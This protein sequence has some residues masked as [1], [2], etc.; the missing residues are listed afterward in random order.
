MFGSLNTSLK[1]RLIIIQVITA[2]VAI[3]LSGFFFVA[4]TYKTYNDREVNSLYSI[5]KVVGDNIVPTLEFSGDVFTFQEDAENTLSSLQIHSNIKNAAILDKRGQLFA[6]YVG[7]EASSYVFEYPALQE[8][9]YYTSDGNFINVYYKL[10]ND[11]DFLGT[12]CLRADLQSSSIL[13]Q[14]IKISAIVLLIGLL[15]SF[16]I[17]TFLQRSISSPILKLVSSMRKVSANQ[18]FSLRAEAEG[19]DEIQELSSVFNDMLEQIQK[20]DQSLIEARDELEVRVEE[21][22]K[23]LQEKTKELEMSNQELEQF[24]Y[25]ASHDLQEPLRM[26]GSFS[27]LIMRRNKEKFDDETKE[28]FEYIIDG[29]SRMQNL[30]SDLL[31]FSRVGTQKMEVKNTDLALVV[32]KCINNLRHTIEENNV[33]ISTENLP[34]LAVDETKIMQLFQNLISNAIKF[35]NDHSP[36]IH[37]YSQ[38]RENDWVFAVKDNGIGIDKEYSDKIFM[39]FQRLHKNTY[40]GTGIGLAICKKI[41]ELHGGNIWFESE[42]GIGSTFFFTLKK[43]Q[44]AVKTL[45]RQQIPA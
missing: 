11:E 36:T 26:I 5:A 34:V 16:I 21:R 17:S 44:A 32:A 42:P 29:V 13:Q 4:S 23:E 39:I 19:V 15:V 31:S 27:Q 7:N 6:N 2:I 24:A 22:T 1:N 43:R 20:R 14:F 10:R 35:R 38:E 41:A 9:L 8:D 28:F 33:Q 25:V 18:D 3:T 37:I 12:M 40:P 30:I 45:S